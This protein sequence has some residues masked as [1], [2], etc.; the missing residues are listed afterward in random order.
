MVDPLTNHF[1][2][3]PRWPHGHAG[4]VTYSKRSP[5]RGRSSLT[6]DTVLL[7]ATCHIASLN[8]GHKALVSQRQ[9]TA[10]S[11]VQS[12]EVF[13][14]MTRPWPPT[15]DHR[16]LLST[17]PRW[18]DSCHQPTHEAITPSTILWSSRLLGSWTNVERCTRRK[19]SS[20][21][22]RVSS[23]PSRVSSSTPHRV[24]R[25][26]VSTQRGERGDLVHS[27]GEQR[28]GHQASL[29]ENYKRRADKDKQTKTL[30]ACPKEKL[31]GTLSSCLHSS[32]SSVKNQRRRET[33][34]TLFTESFGD[35]KQQF[36]SFGLG[37]VQTSFIMEGCFIT[38][39]EHALHEMFS[40]HVQGEVICFNRT[41]T[42]DD[43][44]PP[45][46]RCL[47][48]ITAFI[49]LCLLFYWLVSILWN[50]Y[51]PGTMPNPIPLTNT[52]FMMRVYGAA[53]TTGTLLCMFLWRRYNLE[54]CY[55]AYLS[56]LTVAQ[57]YWI[58]FHLFNTNLLND[59]KK[60]AL[61]ISMVSTKFR[62]WVVSDRSTTS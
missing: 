56:S 22:S 16:L 27:S 14:H 28:C 10:S 54:P 46:S 34:S 42:D 6:H 8:R 44:N 59:Q 33:S 37:S 36:L 41:E 50:E 48:S 61:A 39:F 51:K 29:L 20:L 49:M 15:V 24:W 57:C 30:A 60:P 12:P 32:C 43:G 11:M 26:R 2:K 19:S 58:L 35:S 40:E 38:P 7:A 9:G 25:Q 55:I 21:S 62:D 53:Q 4:A 3:R 23:G 52:P 31:P 13:D 45:E 18:P 1:G 47:T 5:S 17:P